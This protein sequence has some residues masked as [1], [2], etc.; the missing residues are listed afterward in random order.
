M[1]STPLKTRDPAPVD[2]FDIFP[3]ICDDYSFYPSLPDVHFISAGMKWFDWN[4]LVHS[5]W[6]GVVN[7]IPI[8]M[9]G[10]GERMGWT[11]SLS[12]VVPS[13]L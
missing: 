12:Q 6:N 7:L 13:S 8:G 10:T 4:V 5:S 1:V 11:I 9:E 2:V 3:D